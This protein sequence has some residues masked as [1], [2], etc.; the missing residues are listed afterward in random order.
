[1]SY[2]HRCSKAGCRKR[3]T[4]AKKSKDYVVRSHALCPACGNDSLKLDANHRKESKRNRCNCDGAHYPHKRGSLVW[5]IHS[6]R[7]P[8]DDDWQSLYQIGA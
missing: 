1:M 4:L 5:C 3:V 8:S 2:P 6:T 7:Q